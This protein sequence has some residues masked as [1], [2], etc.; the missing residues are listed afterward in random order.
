MKR[1]QFLAAAV[2][3][4]AGAC[5]VSG[6]R[7]RIAPPASLSNERV[8]AL[9]AVRRLVVERTDP[10]L[11]RCRYVADLGEQQVMQPIL[12]A[13]RGDSFDAFIDNALPQPTTVHFHGLA[14]PESADGAGFDPIA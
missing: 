3:S 5:G 13:R 7:D 14:L 11:G 6:K 8:T 4:L 1:R 9:S 10:V 12:V 2:S